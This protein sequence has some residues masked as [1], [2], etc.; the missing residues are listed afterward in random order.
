M[1]SLR[2]IQ[3]LSMELLKELANL[4]AYLG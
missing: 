4:I 1:P 2:V 3:T